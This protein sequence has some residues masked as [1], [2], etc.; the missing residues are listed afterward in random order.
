MFQ[1][2]LLLWEKN[3]FEKKSKSG[4]KKSAKEVEAVEENASNSNS[5]EDEEWN[6]YFYS[7]LNADYWNKWAMI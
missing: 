5:N 2:Y 7:V 3:S 6:E 4:E 1:M